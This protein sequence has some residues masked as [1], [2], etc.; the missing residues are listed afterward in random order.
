MRAARNASTWWHKSIQQSSSVVSQVIVYS[1][2]LLDKWSPPADMEGRLEADKSTK[3]RLGG[4][5]S[6]CRDHSQVLK[7]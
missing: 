3:S 7:I 1:D 4:V 5:D 6:Q 2:D